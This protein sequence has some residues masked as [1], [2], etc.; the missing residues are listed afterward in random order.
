MST[1]TR[2]VPHVNL[3]RIDQIILDTFITYMF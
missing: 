2:L 3:H 1:Y